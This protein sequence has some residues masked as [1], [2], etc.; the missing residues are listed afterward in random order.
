MSDTNIW[1]QICEEYHIPAHL[2]EPVV[3][4]FGWLC[5]NGSGGSGEEIIKQAIA[6]VEASRELLEGA[7]EEYD[8][9]MRAVE[10]MRENDETMRAIEIIEALP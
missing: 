2:R 7:S 9:V 8:E 10:L 4:R 6:D 1:D 3:Q 5:Q